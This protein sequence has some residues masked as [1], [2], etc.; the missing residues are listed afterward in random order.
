MGRYFCPPSPPPPPSSPQ[1]PPPP[2]RAPIPAVASTT[3]WVP[4]LMLCLC[5]AMTLGT[6]VQV[7]PVLPD[8]IKFM[9]TV[10]ED[11]KGMEDADRAGGRLPE[12]VKQMA[13]LI[14]YVLCS[15]FFFVVGKC[16]VPQ[17]PV[18]SWVY[19][20]GASEGQARCLC[21]TAFVLTGTLARRFH[22]STGYGTCTLVLSGWVTS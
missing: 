7:R 5:C 18:G 8:I 17:A 1:P 12:I 11:L 13:G 19:G 22:A 2:A 15:R 14:G 6:E 9:G 20:G 10:S 16:R 4:R 21:S 3:L